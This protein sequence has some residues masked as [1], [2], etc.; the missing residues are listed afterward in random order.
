MKTSNRKSKPVRGL[1]LAA[2]LLGLLSCS[3][4]PAPEAIA[5]G[6]V[7]ACAEAVQQRRPNALRDLIA[8]DYRDAEGRT[9]QEVL[10]IAAGY[11]LR[12]RSVHLITR[13]QSAEQRD[14]R[15]VATV[16]AALAGRP[17]DDVALLPS[18]DADIYWFD[19]ELAKEDGDWR[20][21]C[22]AWRPALVDD[23]LAP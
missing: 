19:V 12:N 16:L 10:G 17:V 6:F 2:V 21:L 8:T 15:I 22:A 4:R 18:M 3:E 20:V 7:D 13:I 5:R 23:F 14:E 1:L 11:L 9:G